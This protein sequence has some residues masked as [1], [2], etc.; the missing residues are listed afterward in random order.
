MTDYYNDLYEKLK[1]AAS[2]YYSGEASPLSDAEYDDGVSTLKAEAESLG[3]SYHQQWDDLFDTTVDAGGFNAGNDDTVIHALPMMSLAK[4]YTEEELSSYLNRLIRN[5]AT[6]FKIQM[7]LDGQS[8]SCVYKNGIL[9]QMS[10]RGNGQEGKDVSHLIANNALTVDN[11]PLKLSKKSATD[12]EIPETLEVRGELLLTYTQFDEASANRKAALGEGFKVYRNAGVGL[13]NSAKEGLGYNASMTF[14]AYRII[15]DGKPVDTA[16]MMQALESYGF[17][18]VDTAT[19]DEWRSVDPNV[20]A[21]IV[22]VDKNHA[23]TAITAVMKIVNDYGEIRERF[24]IPNDGIVIKPVN[25]DEMNEKLGST[26]HHPSSQLAF[27]YVGAR[28]EVTVTGV[29]WSIGKQGHLTPTLTYEP[30]EIDG[31]MN[32]RATIHNP[33]FLRE[34]DLRVGNRVLIERAGGVIPKFID[35][36]AVN[37]NNKRIDIPVSCP[38]CGTKIVF[39]DRIAE[40]PNMNCPGRKSYILY[41]AVGSSALNIKG[42]GPSVIDACIDNGMLTDVP[43][44]FALD[45]K[46]LSMIRMNGGQK[47]GRNAVKVVEELEKARHASFER[48]LASLAIPG[49]AARTGVILSRNGYGSLPALQAASVDDLLNVPDIGIITADAIIKWFHD[50]PDVIARLQSAGVDAAFDKKTSASSADEDTDGKDDEFDPFIKGHSFSITGSAKPAFNSRGELRDYIENNGGKFSA[51][52]NKGTE[53][54]IGDETAD[55]SHSKMKIAIRFRDEGTGLRIITPEEF[56]ESIR[57]K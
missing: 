44:L 45:A 33:A 20:P 27:K 54:V 6:G 2:L 37:E 49:V 17:V 30:E 36:I 11:L 22:D 34:Y 18:T 31:V 52:P 32:D 24:D 13:V 48:I 10:T 46:S 14:I 38:K 57:N 3:A 25:E 7:K 50:N 42:L 12:A 15:E 40:C 9:I 47:V 21:L 4:A 39:G 43:S 26:A 35:V 41:N 1:N 55:A 28:K 23:D 8:L 51:T 53:Y 16:G 56:A 29:E 5:G 19:R